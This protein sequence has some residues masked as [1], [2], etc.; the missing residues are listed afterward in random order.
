MRRH[1]EGEDGFRRLDL[2]LSQLLPLSSVPVLL[3]TCGALDS[4]PGASVR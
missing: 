1:S 2:A 3:V 4:D